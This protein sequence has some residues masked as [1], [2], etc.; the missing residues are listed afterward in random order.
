MPGSET[1]S[2]F[3]QHVLI[4]AAAVLQAAVLLLLLLLLHTCVCALSSYVSCAQAAVWVCLLLIVRYWRAFDVTCQQQRKYS[5]RSQQRSC[6]LSQLIVS[7]GG[8]YIL[9]T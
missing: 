9:P 4:S 3:E 2:Q 7:L 8:C 5:T 1:R 6:Y